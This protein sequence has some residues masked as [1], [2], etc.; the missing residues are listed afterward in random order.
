MTMGFRLGQSVVLRG[1]IFNWKLKVCCDIAGAD[2]TIMRWVAAG[3][4]K[5]R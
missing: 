3:M 5:D 4:P 2:L 1:A